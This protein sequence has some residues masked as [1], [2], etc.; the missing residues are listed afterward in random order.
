MRGESLG[1]GKNKVE[2]YIDGKRV[3]SKKFSVN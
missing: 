3:A 2:V 1:S